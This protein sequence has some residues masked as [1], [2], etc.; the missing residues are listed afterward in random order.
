MLGRKQRPQSNETRRNRQFGVGRKQVVSRAFYLYAIMKDRPNQKAT[1]MLF[2]T[3]MSN[4]SSGGPGYAR[5]SL[6]WKWKLVSPPRLCLP[7]AAQA[8][9]APC[10]HSFPPPRLHSPG[11]PAL[12]V[13]R[14]VVPAPAPLARPARPRPPCSVL[15]APAAPPAE[16]KL[17][18]RVLEDSQR[19]SWLRTHT[20][21]MDGWMDGWMQLPIYVHAQATLAMPAVLARSRHACLS[22]LTCWPPV[23]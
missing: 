9:E 6:P 10:A 17:R 19:C 18:L 20:M 4:L 5:R 23:R 1:K 14:A 2:H 7:A 21:W 16:T 13:G 22:T 8:A 15:A 11:A 3:A 12:L